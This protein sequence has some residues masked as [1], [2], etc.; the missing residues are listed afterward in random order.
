MM[1]QNNLLPRSFY[2][3]NTVLVAQELLGNIIVRV[4]HNQIIAGIISETEAY[5]G[6][7]DPASHAYSKKT[8]RNQAL[9]G[10]VGHSYVYFV[11]GNHYCL[12][13]V[14]RDK[15]LAAGGVL[16]RGLIPLHGIETM[17]KLRHTTVFT[18]LTNGP[19]K[20]GQAL[21]LTRADNDIDLTKKGELYVIE[22]IK[23][24]AKSIDVTPRIG[25]KK[26]Q[27]KL[28]RFVINKEATQTLIKKIND[29]TLTAF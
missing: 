12:N 14:A 22:G 29:G 9:F 5:C 13:L 23:I 17:Q 16:I 8:P 10:P 6:P 1:Q 25:I 4:W 26:A 20:I 11:Y 18:N 15:E 2:Q 24:P 28:W 7:T 27:D 19:G 3:R 21:H